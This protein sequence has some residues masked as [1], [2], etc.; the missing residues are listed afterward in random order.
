MYVGSGYQ[1]ERGILKGGMEAGGYSILGTQK[2]L[3]EQKKRR[4]KKSDLLE[5]ILRT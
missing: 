2:G 4:C 5:S 1:K 3:S